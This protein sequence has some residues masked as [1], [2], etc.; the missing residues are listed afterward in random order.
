MRKDNLVQNVV[1]V[2]LAVTIMV[3][4][5]GYALYSQTLNING[6]A[7]FS[8]ANWDVHF[9]TG[10]FNETSTIKSTTHNVGNTLITYEVTLPRPGTEYSFTVNAKNFG[11]I[12]AVLKGITLSGLTAAQQAYITY[13]VS[14]NG[15]V[16][17]ASATGLSVALA[18]GASHPVI[19]T[20]GY[21]LPADPTAL[22]TVADETVSLTV[23]LDY[24]S[25]N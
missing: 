3:M 7:T 16:Y 23:A 9:D 1:I 8:K 11:T 12:D 22:P 20:V 6:T 5:V 18:S 10:T 19:V 13:N 2:V 21:V 25:A 14:Y 15:T 17:N 24:E 4:S